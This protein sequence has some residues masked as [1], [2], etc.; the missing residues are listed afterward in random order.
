M[1]TILLLIGFVLAAVHFAEAQQL[2]KIPRIG[3]LRPGSPVGDP[4]IESFR[5][6][7]RELGYIEGKNILVEYKYGEGNSE[8]FAI[9]AKELVHLNVDVIVVGGGGSLTTPVKQA[10][11]TIPVVFTEVGDPIGMKLVSSL[12]R[13]GGNITGLSS[14][15]QDLA[16]KRLE[17]LKETAPKTSRVAVLMLPNE[18]DLKDVEA[19][20]K[21]LRIQIT[22]VELGSTDV[23]AA[24]LRTMKSGV[25]ALFALPNRVTNSNRKRIAEFA[26]EKR[27]PLMLP[28]AALMDSGALISYGPDHAELLRRAATYV[29]KIL[30]GVKPTELPVEQPTKFELVINLKTAKQIGLTIPPHVLARA[31]KVIK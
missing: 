3:V 6:G 30:K 5:Q 11:N 25:D 24:L 18:P 27:L 4:N 20:A 26:L 10:T 9:L 14:V 12:A 29:D 15:S 16:G 13:P 19:A 8:R 23:E 21:P 31:N 7:L 2:A 17:L 1:K 22:P 28:D